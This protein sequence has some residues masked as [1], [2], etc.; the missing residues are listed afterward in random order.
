MCVYLFSGAWMNQINPTKL[1]Q[2]KWTAV[3]PKNKEKHFLV[4][5]VK[6]DEAG[7]VIHCA[8]ESVINKKIIAVDW[9]DLKDSDTWKQGWK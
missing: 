7:V 2:S 5:E 9:H 6:L 4:V 3:T 8:L 1:F